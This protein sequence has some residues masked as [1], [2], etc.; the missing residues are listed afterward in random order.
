MQF[1]VLEYTTQTHDLVDTGANPDVLFT[2]P[3]KAFVICE[4]GGSTA[5]SG[6]DTIRGVIYWDQASTPYPDADSV[7]GVLMVAEEAVGAIDR[8]RVKFYPQIVNSGEAIY[9]DLAR[10]GGVRNVTFHLWRVPTTL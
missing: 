3:F 2:M 5:G 8:T 1:P 7:Q 6:T 10:D 4:L 9:M